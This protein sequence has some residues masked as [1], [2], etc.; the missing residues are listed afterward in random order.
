MTPLRALIADDEKP[1]RQ[2]IRRFLAGDPGV[3]T[4]FEAADG[5]A[6]LRIIL[7][8]RPDVVF[9]DLQMP[10]LT[11]MEVA[12]AVP[13]GALPHIVFVTA[14]DSFAVDAFDLPAVDYLLKPF[15]RERFDRALQRARDALGARESREDLE[16]A[17]R[18]LTQHQAA[19]ASRLLV[20]DGGRTVVISV[21]EIES[22]EAERNYVR[23]LA[24]PRAYRIRGT[25]QSLEQRLDARRF[26]RVSRGVIVNLDRV[27]ELRTAGHG[28][29]DML[30]RSGARVRLSRRYRDR[31]DALRS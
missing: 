22:L 4:I 2:K 30:L 25:I 1:G 5:P 10:G 8:E 31:L 18:V 26:A 20:E 17:L 29:S 6:A 11:G 13:P 24:P 16:R 3:A 15:D 27:L 7:E 12:R 14:H 28:D 23:I 21:A 19:A 9:L